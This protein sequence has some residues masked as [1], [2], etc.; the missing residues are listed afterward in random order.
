MAN[1]ATTRQVIYDGLH[2]LVRRG[3]SDSELTG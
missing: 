2:P 3:R 1:H